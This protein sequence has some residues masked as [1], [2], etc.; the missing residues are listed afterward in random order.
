[1]VPVEIIHF[2]NLFLTFFNNTNILFWKK[3]HLTGRD[4]N[5]LYIFNVQSGSFNNSGKFLYT[6]C[7]MIVRF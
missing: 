1:M 3:D 4:K 5:I 7:N 6:Y 2:P